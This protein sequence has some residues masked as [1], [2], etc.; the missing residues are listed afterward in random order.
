[1]G[2]GIE[3]PL[4][5]RYLA[6]GGMGL[7][8]PG[9]GL[10]VDHC[11]T[12]AGTTDVG[13]RGQRTLFHPLPPG[14]DPTGTRPPAGAPSGSTHPEAALSVAGTHFGVGQLPDVTT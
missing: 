9:G 5:W 3:T 13:A 4:V 10:S 14:L 8:P 7:S 12:S 2:G 11:H 1:M 6:S